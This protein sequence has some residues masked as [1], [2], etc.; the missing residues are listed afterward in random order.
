M[1]ITSEDQQLASKVQETKN[2][3]ATTDCLAESTRLFGAP[4]NYSPTASSWWHWWREATGLSG[5][6]SVLSD[7]KA[8]NANGHLRCQIQQLGALVCPVCR[9]E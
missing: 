3:V 4:G 1:K 6:T 5:V 7:V 9:R 2:S 8:C